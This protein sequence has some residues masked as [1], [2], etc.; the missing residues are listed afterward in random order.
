MTTDCR[1]RTRRATPS[2]VLAA[3]T[4]LSVTVAQAEPL[5]AGFRIER[6]Q[7]PT[8][9]GQEKAL[10]AAVWYPT[11]AEEARYAYHV[12]S[13]IGYVAENAEPDREHGPYPLILYSHG[14]G[15]GGI[16][17]VFFTEHLARNGFIVVAPDHS[18]RH[19]VVRTTG[20]LK[21]G[22][23]D[24]LQTAMELARSG[25]S[26]DPEAYAYRPQEAGFALDKM[27]ELNAER[28]WPL[29]GL[30]DPERIGA[31]GHSFGSFTVLSIGG[32]DETYADP[33]LKA[34][35]AFSGGVFMWRPADWRR[36]TIPVMLAYGEK[37][38][39][40]RTRFGARDVAADT[41]RGY[42]NC[43]PPKFL[44][45]LK[46]AGHLTFSQGVIR[47][48]AAAEA[49]GLA[50]EQVRALNRRGLAFLQR[51]VTDDASTEAELL[52]DDPM[53]VT[54]EHELQ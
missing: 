20:P 29:A 31:V 26:L 49:T 32:L 25:P 48:R 21:L 52:A 54:S 4:L 11:Q 51:Y 23:G 42:E 35:L 34:V 1:E 5:N 45:V 24:Y 27:L 41:R 39:G 22:A 10:N 15:G 36:L 33:R 37:E 46:G 9:E 40:Q 7:M 3:L 43:R 44:L 6:W 28:E 18:D 53:W 14:Y 2:V 38:A 16:A 12:P 47:G 30:T 50:A 8:P 19:Q 17:A 13:T